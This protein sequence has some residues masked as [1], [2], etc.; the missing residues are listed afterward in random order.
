[1][2]NIQVLPLRRRQTSSREFSS[3][4]GWGRIR[5]GCAEEVMGIGQE[6]LQ[7]GLMCEQSLQRHGSVL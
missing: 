3:E 5:N 2:S 6:K 1:M 7:G 4:Q